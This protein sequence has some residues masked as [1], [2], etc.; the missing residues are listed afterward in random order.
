MRRVREVIIVIDLFSLV[1]VENC[2]HWF[3]FLAVIAGLVS[4][5]LSPF[6]V[7]NKSKLNDHTKVVHAV[8]RQPLSHSGLVKWI[9]WAAF[10]QAEDSVIKFWLVH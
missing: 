1:W 6:V 3:N 5:R 4:S 7:H 8:T 10:W 9:F 2:L